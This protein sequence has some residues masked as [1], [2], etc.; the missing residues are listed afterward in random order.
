MRHYFTLAISSFLL[1]ACAGTPV[2]QPPVPNEAKS[3]GL[4]VSRS[5]MLDSTDHM[6]VH[7]DSRKEII[8]SQQFGN[9]FAV[10]ALFGPL[11]V[12]ANIAA[13]KV[14]TDSDKEKIFGKISILPS[15]VFDE[16]LNKAELSNSK[17][18]VQGGV[19]LSP[20]MYVVKNNNNTLMFAAAL[21]VEANTPGA[22]LPYAKYMYQL[23]TKLT[24]DELNSF[25]AESNSKLKDELQ[26]GYVELLDFYKSDSPSKIDTEK[27]VRFKSDFLNPRFEFET[28]GK[29]AS[30]TSD[31]VWVR[32]YMGVAAI[33]KSNFNLVGPWE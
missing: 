22:P 10:G 12:L 9:S 11:G 25:T 24:L 21:I 14:K 1:S 3:K 30:E 20:Y 28:P 7:L 5:V 26:H 32:H 4:S 6:T 13:T 33:S 27:V 23:P 2:F 15:A 18:E 19:N 17:S 31:R 8:Y 29:I 16:S